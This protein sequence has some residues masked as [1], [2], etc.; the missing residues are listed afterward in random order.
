[1]GPEFENKNN[2]GTAELDINPRARGLLIADVEIDG[3][4]RQFPIFHW[5]EDSHKIEIAKRIAKGELGVVFGVG[6]YG[7]VK[8]VGDLRRGRHYDSGDR[9]FSEKQGRSAY[10][11]IPIYAP[12]KV[13]GRYMDRRKI[14]PYFRDLFTYEGLKSFYEKAVIGHFI[15]PTFDEHPGLNPIFVTT[16]ED[17]VKAGKPS[18]LWVQ[19]KT[20]SLFWWNDPDASKVADMVARLDPSMTVGISSFNDPG[21]K[22]AFCL[23]DVLNYV[24]N[25]KRVPFDFVVR[26]EIGEAVG[27]KSSHPQLRVPLVGEE[28]IW[29]VVRE[30]SVS[31][32]S[33][34]AATGLPFNAK[35]NNATTMAARDHPNEIVLDP[36]VQEVNLRVQQNWR[37]RKYRL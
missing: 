20:V 23:E 11:K 17:W 10:S 12:F 5:R 36:L 15:V 3:K 28:P 27:V 32:K 8:A 35:T 18:D 16:H 4:P 34:V 37:S 29:T 30:G 9:F 1:M 2:G 31:I 33:F 14:H 25:K 26:D 13:W 24:R 6:N 7:V 19:Q 22:P 21:E